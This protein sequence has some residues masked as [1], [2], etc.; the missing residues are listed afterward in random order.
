MIRYNDSFLDKDVQAEMLD[1]ASLIETRY[2]VV[3]C[4]HA[5]G[6]ATDGLFYHVELDVLLDKSDWTLQPIEEVYTDIPEMVQAY[7]SKCTQ[8]KVALEIKHEL[9][10]SQ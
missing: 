1:L 8:S 2:E 4:I 5:V 7:L 6:K 9:G 10:I 3:H